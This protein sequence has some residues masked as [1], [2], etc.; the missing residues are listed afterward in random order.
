VERDQVGDPGLP[1]SERIDLR[2]AAL[3]RGLFP[4]ASLHGGGEIHLVP[5]CT[6]AHPGRAVEWLTRQRPASSQ[7][8][9]DSHRLGPGVPAR[10]ASHHARLRSSD[11]HCGP[12]RGW[13]RPIDKAHLDGIPSS[14]PRN[15]RWGGLRTPARHPH[16]LHHSDGLPS[17]PRQIVQEGTLSW[18]KSRDQ[19]HH[20]TAGPKEDAGNPLPT[21]VIAAL[22]ALALLAAA[23][24]SS[25][26]STTAT[27]V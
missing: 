3:E 9:R 11:L 22:S 25:R 4:A 21:R 15:V 5:A 23:G 14:V 16:P 24:C 7:S 27:T 17:P 18:P 8:R 2:S 1:Q 26:G 10:A 12:V 13:A 20:R 6:S 19:S